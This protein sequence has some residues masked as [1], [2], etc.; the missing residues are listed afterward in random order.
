METEQPELAANPTTAEIESLKYQLDI[1]KHEMEYI[2]STIARMDEITQTTKN[3]AILVWGGSILLV[4]GD[5]FFRN[6]LFFTALLPLLFWYIDGRWRYL[7]RRSIYR[8]MKINQFLNDGRLVT[9]FQTGKLDSFTVYD[10]A[11]SQ[12]R[13][14]NDQEYLKYVSMKKALSYAEVMG[15]YGVLVMISVFLALIL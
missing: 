4:L 9:A 15:F 12:Y 14:A 1:L 10:P 3:W 11:G 7:Q 2:N 5:P 13:A 6:Y 8:S